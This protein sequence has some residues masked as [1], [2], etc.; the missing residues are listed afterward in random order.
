[1]NVIQ[2]GA[3]HSI[4]WSVPMTFA[5]HFFKSFPWIY[6]LTRG[7]PE[8]RGHR[9]QGWSNCWKHLEEAEG[10]SAQNTRKHEK[11]TISYLLVKMLVG[12]LFT[13]VLINIWTAL[14]SQSSGVV[15]WVSLLQK[16]DTSNIASGSRAMWYE[17]FVCNCM[18][19]CAL[20]LSVCCS[21]GSAPAPRFG[22]TCRFHL[23]SWTTV[24]SSTWERIFDRGSSV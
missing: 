1:M 3:S 5:F 7:T 10:A 8:S 13:C 2:K 9:I 21:S 22:S 12:F 18:C 11:K 6:L 20:T 14:Y 15:E 24:P 16:P 19:V 17:A 4:V 23:S